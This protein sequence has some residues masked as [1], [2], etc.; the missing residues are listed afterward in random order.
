MLKRSTKE[1]G[2]QIGKGGRFVLNLQFILNKILL[3][4]VL[5][6]RYVCRMTSFFGFILPLVVFIQ[7]FVIP[8]DKL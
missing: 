5:I 4:S 7:V 3:Q 2:M 6:L 1:K 8:G